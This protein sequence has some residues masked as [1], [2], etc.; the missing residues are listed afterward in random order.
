MEVVCALGTPYEARAPVR[1]I[2]MEGSSPPVFELL[3]GTDVLRA[4]G[5][6]VD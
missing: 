6:Y 3:L 1:L 2:V 5:A 4:L